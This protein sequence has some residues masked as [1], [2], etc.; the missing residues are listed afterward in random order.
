MHTAKIEIREW[1]KWSL[2]EVIKTM[3]NRQLTVRTKKWSRSNYIW[4]PGTFRRR[5]VFP[6]DNRWAFKQKSIKNTQQYKILTERNGSNLSNSNRKSALI[7]YSWHASHKE[8][9]WIKKSLVLR[10][11]GPKNLAVPQ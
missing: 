5:S 10:N 8:A 6:K 11:C 9:K 4:K 3:E 2:Q 1:V 7:K